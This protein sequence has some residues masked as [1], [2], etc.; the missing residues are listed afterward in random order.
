[1][2]QSL[3]SLQLV[4]LCKLRIRKEVLE[5]LAVRG[6]VARVAAGG[7]VEY[8]EELLPVPGLDVVVLSVLAVDEALDDVAIVVEDAVGGQRK[9]TGRPKAIV[10]I[11]GESSY[12]RR[13]AT[14]H[15][16]DD[17]LQAL[18]NHRRNLLH[19]Q[20]LVVREGCAG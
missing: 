14:D 4:C 9:E 19:A 6:P 17:R 2:R 18:S 10:A 5:L 15:L 8:V 12:I 3:Y 13:R 16:H 20:L 1:M 11:S 7:R